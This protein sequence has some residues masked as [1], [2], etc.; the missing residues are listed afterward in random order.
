MRKYKLAVVVS[1]P[2]QYQ[3]SLYRKLAQNP[4]LDLTVY[5]CTDFGVSSK[6]DP[7]FGITFKW[8]IPLLEGYRYKFLRNYSIRPSTRRFGQINP[9]IIPELFVHRYDA[10]LLHGY[11]TVKDWLTLIGAWFSRTPVFVRGESH[12]LL[13][14]SSAGGF[15]RRIMLPVFFKKTSAALS[16]GSK[17]REFYSFYGVPFD[18]IFQAPYSVDNERF[19]DSYAKLKNQKKNIKE[20]LKLPQN[21]KIIL[22]ASKMSPRKRPFDLL[23]AYEKINSNGNYSLAFVGDGVLRPRLERYS[24]EARLKN[25]HFFGFQ[26]QS[27]LIQF[28]SIADVFVLPSQSEPWGLVINEAMNFQIPIITTDS[29]GAA[30]DLIKEGQNG[31]VYEAGNVEALVNCLKDVLDDAGKAQQMGKLSQDIISKWSYEQDEQGILSALRK[32]CAK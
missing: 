19:Q 6:K 12:L 1:H 15:V 18:K 30:Y 17:N 2:I 4:H 23:K 31:F 25:V 16:I 22:Y 9:G 26:N 13:S 28:Y 27:E 5:F 29:V 21:T 32:C 7:G 8:D 11:T 20:Q 24:Q 10:V 3:V 14:R